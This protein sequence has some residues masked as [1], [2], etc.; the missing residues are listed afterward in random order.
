MYAKYAKLRDE[1]GLTDN[2]VAVATRIPQSTLY[3]WKQRSERD[4]KA[5]LSFGHLVRIANYFGVSIEYFATKE[6]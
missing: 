2:A 4:E 1:R 5:A 6:D 3:D